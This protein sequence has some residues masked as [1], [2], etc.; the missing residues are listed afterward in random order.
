MNATPWHSHD[1]TAGSGVETVGDT[2][3]NRRTGL[4][5]LLL[6]KE[7]EEEEEF[8]AT[9]F[10]AIFRALPR[11]EAVFMSE[12][13]SLLWLQKR[14]S[15]PLAPLSTQVSRSTITE[16]YA[17]RSRLRPR[18]AWKTRTSDSLIVASALSCTSFVL[19]SADLP[20][21]RTTWSESRARATENDDDD[22][23]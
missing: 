7:E 21:T 8:D 11:L 5:L 13:M 17:Q 10:L 18:P 3:P 15:C 19:L 14:I 2:Y 12:V 23:V 4:L 16:V 1:R 20:F 22:V 9:T 6:L